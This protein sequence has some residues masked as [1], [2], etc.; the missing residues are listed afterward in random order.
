MA[1]AYLH[2]TKRVARLH[3]PVMTDEF[4]A[5]CKP[6][7]WRVL[8]KGIGYRVWRSESGHAP[9]HIVIGGAPVPVTLERVA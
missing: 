4:R 9:V 7:P 2:G 5:N 3:D 1:H 8:I 6:V